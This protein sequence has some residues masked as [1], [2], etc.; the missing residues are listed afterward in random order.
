MT[1]NEFREV[2]RNASYVL[3]ISDPNALCDGGDVYID[4]IKV[5]VVYDELLD[6]GILSYVDLGFVESASKE[7]IFEKMMSLNL[8]LDA[9]LGEAICFESDSSH[10]VLRGFTSIIRVMTSLQQLFRNSKNMLTLQ[11]IYIAAYYPK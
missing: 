3:N 1:N 6:D 2:C 10:L 8:E 7:S 9:S 4:G 5:G 11:G